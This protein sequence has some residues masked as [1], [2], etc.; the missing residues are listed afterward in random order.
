MP[1]SL[2]SARTKSFADV[3]Q[4]EVRERVLQIIGDIRS[5]GDAA[6]RT[7]SETFDKWSPESFRLSDERVQEIIAGSTS[8]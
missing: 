6:V 4:D 3:A 8:R 2:K 5:T 1:T 7:Y